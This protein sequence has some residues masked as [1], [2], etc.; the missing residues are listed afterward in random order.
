MCNIRSWGNLTG[1]LKM[2]PSRLTPSTAR[3]FDRGP[4]AIRSAVRHTCSSMLSLSRAVA[5][6]LVLTAAVSAQ[7][8][9]RPPMPDNVIFE[10]ALDYA[11]AVGG[12]L[13]MDIVRPRD[14]SP[15]PHPAVLCIHGG[16][17]RAGNRES[18]LPL[19]IRLAQ[20][21]YVAAT[22]TYRLAPKFQ[23]PAPLHDVKAAVR[24]LRA[25]A[26]KF[27]IDA[28]PLAVTRPSARRPLLPSLC[29]APA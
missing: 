3:W 12:K 2:S 7:T 13:A 6:S 11:P 5:L 1:W 28:D 15:S 19:C 10:R 14:S 22:V 27:R 26:A 20:R 29:R 4:L 17:F 8:P 18:Y 16:G 21:G 24:Y 25:N 9:R 23:F